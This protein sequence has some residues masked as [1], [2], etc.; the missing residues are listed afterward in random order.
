MTAEQH[1][2][3][4]SSPFRT[5]TTAFVTLFSYRIV[6]SQFLVCVLLGWPVFWLLPQW[7]YADRSDQWPRQVYIHE[8]VQSRGKTNERLIL[9]VFWLIWNVSYIMFV[10]TQ[11]IKI[12]AIPP[13]CTFLRKNSNK[14]T[15]T[16][17][18]SSIFSAHPAMLS[19]AINSVVFQT[20]HWCQRATFW[21]VC[22]SMEKTLAIY[23]TYTL[24]PS[25]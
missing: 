18:W 17:C 15:D 5:V 20:H 24:Q 23:Y 3:S 14:S 8:F 12:H 9:C 4:S 1:V 19:L 16:A 7:H 11:Y 22:M 6:V 21:G 13:I 25:I 2:L 10:C